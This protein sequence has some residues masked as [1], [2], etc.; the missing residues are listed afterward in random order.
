[1]TSAAI[2][3]ASEQEP[4]ANQQ[5]DPEQRKQQE[6]RSAVPTHHRQDRLD[7]LEHLP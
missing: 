2:V 7:H 5:H 1:M 4:R 6:P 3:T